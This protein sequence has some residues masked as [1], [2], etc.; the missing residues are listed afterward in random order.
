MQIIALILIQQALETNIGSYC[1][2]HGA[3][4]A[5]IAAQRLHDPVVRRWYG[6]WCWWFVENFCEGGDA[7]HEV[8]E[9]GEVLFE[10]V[11]DLWEVVRRGERGADCCC[12][13]LVVCAFAE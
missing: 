5:G 1:E 3:E 7:D 10:I 4:G 8:L 11:D 2:S 9:L 6:A 13:D 12:V